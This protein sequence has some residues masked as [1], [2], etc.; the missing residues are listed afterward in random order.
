MRASCEINKDKTAGGFLVRA[1]A[2]RCFLFLHKQ[3][4]GNV[5]HEY[6]RQS[7]EAIVISHK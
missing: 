3:Q 2:I 1:A 5:R 7:Y 4:D 6:E